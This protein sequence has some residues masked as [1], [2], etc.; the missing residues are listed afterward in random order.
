[1][2]TLAEWSG[3]LD[4]I[5]ALI[6]NQDRDPASGLRWSEWQRR[7]LQSGA[8]CKLALTANQVGKTTCQAADLVMEIRGNHPYR[9]RQWE[10]PLNIIMVGESIQQLSQPG[11]PLDK[12][13]GLLPKDEIDPGTR[14]VR[15]KGIRGVKDPIIAFVKGPGAGTIISVRTYAQQASTIAGSTVHIVWCDEPP[16]ETTYAELVP[17]LLHHRGRFVI[18]FTPTLGMPDQ[19]WLRA[20][21]ECS[22]PIFEIHHVPISEAATWLEGYARP[23]MPQEVIDKFERD[24][25]EIER[26][27]R[28]RA[29]WEPVIKGAAI[30]GFSEASHVGAFVGEHALPRDGQTRIIVCIDHG[31]KAGKQRAMLLYCWNGNDQARARFWWAD[32][33]GQEESTTSRQDATNILEMLDRNGLKYT[34]VDDWVGDVQTGDPRVVRTKTNGTL[35]RALC[36][37]LG[38]NATDAEMLRIKLPNKYKG[39]MYTG[40]DVMSKVFGS[41]RGRVAPRCVDFIAALKRFQFKTDDPCKDILDAGRYGMELG[42]DL[43]KTQPFRINVKPD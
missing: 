39:S 10:G 21:V 32:E 19:T 4:G 18:T 6:M 28:L 15:G 41:G 33:C 20:M 42:L 16:N 26:G 7:W 8:A 36:D 9:P 30:R 40:C 1:V 5:D 3:D 34:H 31:L 37:L 29:E 11:G 13:W 14:F 2:N 12:L 38:T 27:M 23:L 25:P 43:K 35:R 24:T 22:P 17:R